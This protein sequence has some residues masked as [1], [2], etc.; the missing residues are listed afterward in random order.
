MFSDLDAIEVSDV[1]AKQPVF[2]CI[3]T[4]AIVGSL[5]ESV[6]TFDEINSSVLQTYLPACSNSIHNHSVVKS[7]VNP[8]DKS[9]D[10]TSK[11]KNSVYN[12]AFLQHPSPLKPMVFRHYLEQYDKFEAA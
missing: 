10:L 5:K 11:S 4:S 6:V 9:S 3:D 12:T 8:C 2:D 1:G 7:V